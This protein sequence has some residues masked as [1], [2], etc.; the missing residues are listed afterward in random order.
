MGSSA[1]EKCEWEGWRRSDRL[2][3]SL[4]LTGRLPSGRL[5]ALLQTA[6][7]AARAELH[8]GLALHQS[9]RR[10]QLQL[11]ALLDQRA[12]RVRAEAVGRAKAQA[13]DG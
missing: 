9:L 8:R 10:L 4:Q 13:S 11:T 2:S 7:A 5:S 12:L 6:H 1:E 3:F